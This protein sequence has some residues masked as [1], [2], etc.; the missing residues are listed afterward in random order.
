MNSS[1]PTSKQ[2]AQT[3]FSLQPTT[4]NGNGKGN[5]FGFTH[6]AFLDTHACMHTNNY[7][8]SLTEEFRPGRNATTGRRCVRERTP[9][10]RMKAAVGSTAVYNWAVQCTHDTTRH[11][12]PHPT[13]QAPSTKH[14]PSTTQAPSTKHQ[15][16]IDFTITITVV[17]IIVV[18]AVVTKQKYKPNSTGMRPQGMD[19]WMDGCTGSSPPTCNEASEQS[20]FG[21]YCDDLLATVKTAP[22]ATAY[23][24]ATTICA[25]WPPTPTRR[26]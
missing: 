13:H 21:A 26:T 1:G 9:S 5:D 16:I 8:L 19:G 20:S 14:H 15:A 17:I 2:A 6:D 25:S 24:N 22:V 3:S 4:Q 18:V 23:P 10:R 11:D 7:S 12:N